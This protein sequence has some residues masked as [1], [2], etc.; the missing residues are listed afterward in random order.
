[1]A[2]TGLADIATRD[3]HPLEAS[4]VLD[5]ATKQLAIVGLDQGA[6]VEHQPGLADPGGEVI[7][8]PLELAEAK[9]AR[10]GGRRLDPAIEVD[11]GKGLGEEASQ[12]VLE[13]PNLTAQLGARESL[14]PS[15]PKGS[16]SFSFK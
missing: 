10:L 15:D 12:L 14:V 11:T 2:A 6:L 16:E 4:R 9:D 13:T 1:V 5:H 8:H 7:A 3:P